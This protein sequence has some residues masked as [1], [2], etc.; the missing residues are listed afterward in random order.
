MVSCNHDE[1]QWILRS[2]GMP[3]NEP[4]LS[5][6][7][8]SGL[9][10]APFHLTYWMVR[11]RWILTTGE[12]LLPSSPAAI[13]APSH[14]SLDL[15][16]SSSTVSE[17]SKTIHLIADCWFLGEKSDILWVRYFKHSVFALNPSFLGGDWAGSVYSSSGCPSTCVGEYTLYRHR[18]LDTDLSFL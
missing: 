16:I 14:P 1:I 9:V 6:R 17:F 11:R 2:L 3:W 12:P 8:G 5:S 18:I 10:V 13:P 4:I 7:S 15:I